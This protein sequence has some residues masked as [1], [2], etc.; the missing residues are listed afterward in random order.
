MSKPYFPLRLGALLGIL[1]LFSGCGGGPPAAATAPPVVTVA[2]PVEQA[3]TD[4]VDFSG[5]TAAV[6]SVQLRARVGGYLDKVK[7]KEGDEVKKDQVLFAID[8]RPYQADLDRAKARVKSAEAR[9]AQAETEYQRTVRLRSNQAASDEDVDKALRTRDVAVAARAAAQAN[10]VVQQINL[11]FTKVL[12]PIDGRTDKADVTPGNM[13]SAN[14]NDATILTNLVRLEPMYAYFEVGELTMIRIL[15]LI[16]EGKV[17][18]REAKAPEVLLGLGNGQDYPIHGTIDFVGNE[19]NPSTGTITVR[20]VFPNKDR[21]LVPGLF[22]HIRVP[23]GGP[24]PALLVSDRA[25]GTTQGQKFLYVVNGKDQVEYRPVTVGALHG[26]L[27]EVV[28]GLKPGER[29]VINGL[30]RVRPGVTVEPKQGA[31]QAEPAGKK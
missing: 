27:R 10:V 18:S 11:D 6:E 2:A 13:V 21:A 30:L 12:A 4:S 28:D 7:F 20:G 26:G 9:I 16:Q 25:L 24:H 29:V 3:V 8:P 17:P 23:L 14:L 5:Q 22:A 19:L 1:P 15:R 31:M